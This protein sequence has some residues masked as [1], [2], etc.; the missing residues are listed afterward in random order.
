M[1]FFHL[2]SDFR[3]EDF[4]KQKFILDVCLKM[5]SNLT[6]HL[7]GNVKHQLKLI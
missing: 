7:K 5:K 4:L 1:E 2:M 3:A 6:L